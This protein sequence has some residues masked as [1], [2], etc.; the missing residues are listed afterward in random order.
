MNT[1]F[2]QEKRF[3]FVEIAVAI[4]DFYYKNKGKFFIPILFPE[5]TSTVAY[6][7]SASR[8]STSN[9][10]NYNSRHGI[11]ATSVSN[12][13]EMKVPEYIGES[14][15][16]EYNTIKAG[17]EFLIVFVGGEIN[18]PKIIGVNE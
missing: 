11:E 7:N 1:N 17:T 16:N 6:T 9:I 18:N 15:K 14:L 3:E 13:V 4:E 10:L 12:Y 5:L 2:Y 8:G